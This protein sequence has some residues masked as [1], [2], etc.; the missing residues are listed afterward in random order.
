MLTDKH[1]AFGTG[2]RDDDH[3]AFTEAGFE[4]QKD[5]NLTAEKIQACFQRFTENIVFVGFVNE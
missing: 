5:Q 1:C 4:L 3:E 2:V